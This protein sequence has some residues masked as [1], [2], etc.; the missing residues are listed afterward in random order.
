[1][2]EIVDYKQEMVLFYWPSQHEVQ[3]LSQRRKYESNLDIKKTMEYCRRLCAEMD[4]KAEAQLKSETYLNVRKEDSNNDDINMILD[5]IASIVKT[6]SKVLSSDEYCSMQ[7]SPIQS[8]E[9]CCWKPYIESFPMLNLF[10]YSSQD[11][12]GVERCSH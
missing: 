8:R 4:S 9:S 7:G 1:M 6:N 10:K 3:I 12:W 11:L 2:G 5:G